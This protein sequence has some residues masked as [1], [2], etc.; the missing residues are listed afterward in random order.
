MVTGTA[1]ATLT[2]GNETFDNLGNP[3]LSLTSNTG[4]GVTTIDGSAVSN[5]SFLII[6]D[7]GAD[8]ADKYVGGSGDDIFRFDGPAGLKANDTVTGNGGSDTVQLDASAAAVTAVLDL[9]TT[10]VE[11]V[12]VYAG[13]TGV[14]AGQVTL[15][16]GENGT[17]ALN[18]YTSPGLDIDLSGAVNT[19]VAGAV[20]N[21][22][23]DGDSTLNLIIQISLVS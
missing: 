8:T 12:V 3:S 5:G 9:D 16:L 20:V 21:Y 2:F 14:E 19:T 22:T 10:S 11:K 15:Q 4:S 7:I 17:A 18:A 23:D 13:A 6:N 1:A